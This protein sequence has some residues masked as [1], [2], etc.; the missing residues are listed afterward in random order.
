MFKSLSRKCQ[1]CIGFMM[2]LWNLWSDF[3]LPSSL[4]RNWRN[5]P[6]LALRVWMSP[7]LSCTALCLKFSWARILRPLW[8][9]GQEVNFMAVTQGLPVSSP[10]GH[11]SADSGATSFRKKVKEAYVQT[12]KYMQEMPLDN[13]VLH[14]LSAIHPKAMGDDAVEKAL[15]KLPRY[16][17]TTGVSSSL[18]LE[19]TALQLDRGLPSVAPN[20]RMDTWWA[21]VFQKGAYPELSKIV[22]AALNIITG[23]H[24]EG[25]FSIMNNLITTKTA[26]TEVSTY[27][28]YR[29]VKSFLK[30]KQ[31]SSL[32][33]FQREDIHYSDIDRSLAYHLQTASGRHNAKRNTDQPAAVEQASHPAPASCHSL[34]YQTAQRIKGQ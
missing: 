30:A 31:Q 1:W 21:A 29:R 9:S 25:S 12:A 26:R 27:S 5:S 6:P 11:L 3:S 14:L 33:Y 4:S 8:F 28:A 20:Q 13:R 32:E 7:T 19:A 22:K 16:F 18:E 24:V 23:P 10:H 34:V 17:P 2:K 15:R